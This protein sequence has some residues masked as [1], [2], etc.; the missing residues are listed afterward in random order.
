MPADSAK[1]VESIPV[2]APAGGSFLTQAPEATHIFTV[3]ALNDEQ[4]AFAAEAQR[5]MEKEVHPRER[6]LE[7]KEGKAARDMI[8]VL[9][10]ACDLGFCQVEVP[11][12]YGG[13]GADKVTALLVTD[14]LGSSGDFCVT[15]GAHSGIG[16]API[17]YF[18]NDAQKKK[19][20]PKIAEGKT[21]SCYALSEPGSGSDALAARTV[22]KLNEAG[23]H[24]ILNGTKQW[25]TNAAW[26]DVGVVFAKVDGDKFT[27][28]I[29][30]RG[31]PGFTIGNE[32]HKLGLRGSSTCQLIFENAPIPVENVLG[33]VGKGHRIAFN[34]LNLG[35]YKL[36]V[37]VVAMAKR[38]LTE[39]LQYAGDRKQF[40]TRVVDFGAIREQ[41]A[42]SVVGVYLGESLTYRIAGDI[43]Q[44]LAG[45]SPADADY[46]DKQMAAIEEYAVEA[47]I[48]KVFC[49]EMLDRVLD[50][51][52]QW[53]GGYGFVEDYNIE[54]FVRDARVNRIFEG[55][56]E[57][58]RLLIP[59]TLTKRAMQ[60]R[61]DLTA[62]GAELQ[63]RLSAGEL[64][65][66]PE[67]D[68]TTATGRLALAG[69]ALQRLKWLALT[70]A[71]AAQTRHGMA[72]EGQQDLLVGLSNLLI[73]AYAIDS[74]VARASQ[75][76]DADLPVVAACCTVAALEALDRAG[77]SAKR[78]LASCYAGAE[79]KPYLK[80]VD[81]LAVHAPAD[82]L[83]LKR[84]IAA[85]TVA[86]GGYKLG[87]Y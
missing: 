71:Q 65:A 58:N 78:L 7:S 64:P 40:G 16:L 79:L 63:K 5:F 22:A 56:N 45:V 15:W 36:G 34:T 59:G 72:L 9:K 87:N 44:R 54:K 47:S 29:V 85:D 86:R 35:R 42:D 50:R 60:R 49:S 33:E 57:I 31:T 21:V 52:L 12:R 25:I 13:L 37:G 18:G 46:T 74:G 84:A 77:T 8:G 26:M 66:V 73:D 70:V 39:A 27:G 80:A 43:D 48:A 11:E 14:K 32:E 41:L 28:F 6:R 4:R 53:H 2:T 20:V 38:A 17:L 67:A 83:G 81:V 23:T 68:L 30:E 10:K 76:T 62:A 24:Y 19:Y 51:A 3:E 69:W 61:L 55:T 82:V 75:R 1:R